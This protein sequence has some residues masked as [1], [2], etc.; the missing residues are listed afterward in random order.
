MRTARQR[1]GPRALVHRVRP[2]GWALVTCV[3]ERK[4]ERARSS[5]GSRSRSRSRSRLRPR[6]RPRLRSRSRSRLRPRLR[7]R[8]RSR[9]RSRS[10]LRPRLRSRSRRSF[11][12]AN[13]S[14]ERPAPW[15]LPM[16]KCA[17]DPALP[18]GTHRRPLCTNVQR[19]DPTLPR[20]PAVPSRAHDG[21]ATGAHAVRHAREHTASH[22][23]CGPTIR[24]AW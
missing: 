12:P 21:A 2:R 22:G 18:W 11:P 13:T 8:L 9:S 1:R 24:L 15:P 20:A 5:I 19:W 4:E 3:G 10:R 7:P 16:H 23:A 6:L 17:R 14:H